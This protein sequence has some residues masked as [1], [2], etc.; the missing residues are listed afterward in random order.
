MF[1]PAWGQNLQ[2][3][4]PSIEQLAM[5]QGDVDQDGEIDVVLLLRNHEIHRDFLNIRSATKELLFLDC[6]ELGHTDGGGFSFSVAEK[7]PEHKA[8]G[9]L[10][11]L[12]DADF[13]IVQ[14]TSGMRSSDFTA[15]HLTYREGYFWVVGFERD[16]EYLSISGEFARNKLWVDFDENL[17]KS[18]IISWESVHAEASPR[19]RE[20]NSTSYNVKGPYQLR[21]EDIL[22]DGV[23]WWQQIPKE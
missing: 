17:A 2:E 6:G 5:H 20:E 8:F 4:Y 9:N 1:N 22:P 10:I 3:K 18:E 7:W 15:W 13:V 16:Y 23:N 12:S 11:V 14:N 19:D 21:K